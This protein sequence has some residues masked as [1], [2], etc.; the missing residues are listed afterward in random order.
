MR[1]DYS[2]TIHQG[3]KQLEEHGRQ[4]RGTPLASHDRLLQR[5]QTGQACSLPEASS[6][7]RL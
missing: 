6:P 1:I 5:V 2:Q 7:A 3:L 4:L